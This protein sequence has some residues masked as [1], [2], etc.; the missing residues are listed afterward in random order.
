MIQ[1]GSVLRSLIRLAASL[2]TL[3]LCSGPVVAAELAVTAPESVVRSAPFDVAP[4][5]GRVH[6][7]DRLTA[8]D[9]AQGV[10]RRV[11]LSDG[12]WGFLHE[13]EIKV[14]SAPVPV[15]PTPALAAP[16]AAAPAATPSPALVGPKQV[17]VRVTA[18]ELG[19]RATAAAEAPVSQTLHQNDV[20]KAFAD[21]EDGW[22][23]IELSAGRAGFVSDAGVQVVET[24]AGAAPGAVATAGVVAE[25]PAANP[26]D[27]GAPDSLS[28]LTLLGAIFEL[29]PLGRLS[30]G[31]TG[32]ASSTDAASAVAV[33]PFLD[34]PLAP[35]V[36]LGFSP[37]FIFGVKGSS[38][39]D[40]ATEYDL[41]AR[42]TGRYPVS[43]SARTY[44]RF[45]PGYSLIS[46]PGSSSSGGGSDPTGLS[47]DFAIGAEVELLPKLVLV[48]DLGYQLGFQ[49]STV[50]DATSISDGTKVD[51]HTSY[52]HLGAGLAVGL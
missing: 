12:R 14:T 7:G 21:L 17:V 40:S 16:G 42:L 9:Q 34:V 48:V 33:A 10:W 31:P 51:F 5:I 44:L 39:S 46:L 35:Y 18:L 45:S 1:S 49:S 2:F 13:A 20:V 47:L 43:P 6:A 19:V 28:E 3:V 37:Q 22:R 36:S 52:L 24:Y 41:R 4:E 32:N 38:A 15:A 30:A 23:R 29:L 27:R 25:T 8:E 11:Q 50:S 26:P